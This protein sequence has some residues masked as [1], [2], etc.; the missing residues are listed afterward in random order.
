MEQLAMPFL[1]DGEEVMAQFNPAKTFKE[2][3]ADSQRHEKAAAK[4]RQQQKE[5]WAAYSR[6]SAVLNHLRDLFLQEGTEC[7]LDVQKASALMV[8]YAQSLPAKWVKA[9]VKFV[10]R[11]LADLAAEGRLDKRDVRFKEVL[12]NLLLVANACNDAKVAEIF[13]VAASAYPS[14]LESFRHYLLNWLA[15]KI[16]DTWPP[17]P[18]ELKEPREASEAEV[19]P[20]EGSAVA[21]PEEWLPATEALDRAEKCGHPVTL[22]WLTQNAQKHGV[23]LRPRQQPGRHRQEVEWTSLILLLTKRAQRKRESDDGVSDRLQEA[24]AAKQRRR[25]LE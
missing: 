5:Q 6:R 14:D 10:S 1:W 7:T 22:K 18:E 2:I 3:R 8:E 20:S 19:R 23:H 24:Q 17:L 16:V 11:R 25:S 9:R 15:D 12:L 4:M 13:G 21:S